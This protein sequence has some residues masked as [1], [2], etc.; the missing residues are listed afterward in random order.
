MLTVGNR[1]LVV[2]KAILQF[3]RGNIIALLRMDGVG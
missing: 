2:R 3:A 1:V